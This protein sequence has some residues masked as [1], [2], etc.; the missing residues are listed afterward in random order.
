MPVSARTFQLPEGQRTTFCCSACRSAVVTGLSPTPLSYHP[1][2]GGTGQSDCAVLAAAGVVRPSVQLKHCRPSGPYDPTGQGRI[3]STV[4]FKLNTG[5]KPGSARLQAVA[6]SAEVLAVV[7][8]AG[9]LWQLC[10]LLTPSLKVPLGH[11]SACM[12][13]AHPHQQGST[14]QFRWLAPNILADSALEHQMA[15]LSC[16]ML[17]CCPLGPGPTCT[18]C[19]TLAGHWVQ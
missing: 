15:P 6:E 17:Y 7:K 18:G 4:L 10:R 11:G 1:Y 19:R 5:M 9:Q 14:A 13:C 12:L 16:G 3:A 8:P 2:P